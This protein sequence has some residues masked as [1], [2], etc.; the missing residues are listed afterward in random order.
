MS[1]KHLYLLI[2]NKKHPTDNEKRRFK[3]LYYI[4]LQKY[5]FKKQFLYNGNFSFEYVKCEICYICSKSV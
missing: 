3:Y 4:L 5:I 2:Y 1:H